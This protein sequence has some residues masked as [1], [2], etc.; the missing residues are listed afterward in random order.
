MHKS[1]SVFQGL[2][3]R[4]VLDISR[5]SHDSWGVC[6]CVCVFQQDHSL[7]SLTWSPVRWQATR[8][9]SSNDGAERT[10]LSQLLLLASGPVSSANLTLPMLSTT[11]WTRRQQTRDETF[12]KWQTGFF[13]G[14]L[15]ENYSFK[16]VFRG[17]GNSY[18]GV[19]RGIWTSVPSVWCQSTL[20]D[21][22]NMSVGVR[23]T[24]PC[25]S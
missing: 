12:L 4:L 14:T 22:S 15:S 24:E 7:V 1:N 11:C 6:L 19:C 18:W 2:G 17:W 23:A 25:Q 10:Y 5:C 20:R 16:C 3:N 9:C 8:F 21:R 13:Y